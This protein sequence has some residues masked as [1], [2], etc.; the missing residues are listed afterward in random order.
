MFIENLDTFYA[1]IES[2]NP[3][4]NNTVI[5]YSSGYKATA[6]RI[7]DKGGNKM[8]FETGCNF[9]REGRLEFLSWFHSQNEMEM[10]VYFW[11]D[12]DYSGIG[13]LFALKENFASLSAWEIGYRQMLSSNMDGMG[14]TPEM[15]GKEKQIE[16]SQKTECAYSDDVLSL[17]MKDLGTFVDQEVVNIELLSL[18]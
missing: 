7:R 9:S 12:L 4:F 11:G 2:N 5:I 6:K 1:S 14:H 3:V 13:I 10:E 16:L 18:R 15:A 17:N 8:F